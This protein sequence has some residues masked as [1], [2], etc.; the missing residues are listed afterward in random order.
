[1]VDELEGMGEVLVRDGVG[2][3]GW[4]D[5]DMKV[6]MM[7]GWL[8]WVD[9]EYGEFLVVGWDFGVGELGRMDLG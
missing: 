2:K 9:G 7:V 5:G 1:M 3:L 6:G 8:I 4:G